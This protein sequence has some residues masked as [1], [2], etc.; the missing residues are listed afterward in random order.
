[1]FIYMSIKRF[2]DFSALDNYD[3]SWTMLLMESLDICVCVCVCVCV[4]VKGRG[5]TVKSCLES[6]WKELSR[7]FE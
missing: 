3:V 1:M 4:R 7:H 2:I 5:I 6:F